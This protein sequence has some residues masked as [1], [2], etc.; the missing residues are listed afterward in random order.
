MSK[1]Y[2]IKFN[3]AVDDKTNAGV[4]TAISNLDKL[5]EGQIQN[6]KRLAEAQR[7]LDKERIQN[8]N[9]IQQDI[10]RLADAENKLK[11]EELNKIKLAESYK[12]K[13][14]QLHSRKSYMEKVREL[15]LLRGQEEKLRQ[16]INTKNTQISRLQGFI[17]KANDPVKEYD[18]TL[19]MLAA[20]NLRN[21][22]ET[23][24]GQTIA[25]NNRERLRGI[26]AAEREA[27][28]IQRQK[29]TSILATGAVG[30]AALY[31]GSGGIKRSIFE[32]MKLEQVGIQLRGVLG[33]KSGI[34][35]LKGLQDIAR[36]T[37]FNLDDVKQIAMG[38]VAASRTGKMNLST[39]PQIQAQQILSIT[40]QLSKPI[41]AFA[42]NREDR[43]EIVNQLFQVI[44]KGFADNRQD[45]RV[46]MSRGLYLLEP[47]LKQALSERTG[48][49]QNRISIYDKDFKTTSKDMLRAF[50]IMSKTDETSRILGL[51][52]K[53]LTQSTEALGEQFNYTA[54]SVGIFFASIF[55]LPKLFK[56]ISNDLQSIE[57][58]LGG[59]KNGFDMTAISTLTA[60]QQMILYSSVV[61]G[62]TA[63]IAAFR[64]GLLLLQKFGGI[65]ILG[66]AFLFAN[67]LYLAF[68]DIKGAIHDINQEGLK[69]LLKHLDL[70]VAGVAT[71]AGIAG[72][73]MTG[74]I[75][76]AALLAATALG[77]TAFSI[78][79]NRNNNYT[80]GASFPAQEDMS[81]WNQAVMNMTPI[82]NMNQAPQN[83][84]P[85]TNIVINTNVDSTGQSKVSAEVK[86]SYDN[87]YIYTGFGKKIAIKY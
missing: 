34:A 56:V 41:L 72:F 10:K 44:S 9:R 28:R 23:F 54:G 25:A 32:G 75:P 3:V 71:I 27:V 61:M 8:R 16:Y 33:E 70:A 20:T 12:A 18:L 69:G 55:G 53:S 81:L 74:N 17:G 66:K 73:L 42:S 64:A 76:A 86:S 58:K 80:G 43:Q 22:A 47:A 15:K 60:S 67:A 36:Q 11:N 13:I 62:A 45:T 48:I 24:L 40:K 49:S 5:T 52:E 77:A 82:Q 39:N 46:M 65:G 1:D 19:K 30:T 50:E 4:A 14:M 21:R 31:K 83:F 57:D 79:N 59:S 6:L 84:A 35:T 85:M 37:A 26:R 2:Q 51:R 87:P 38:V 68:G 78:Y 29:E 63:A 7:L